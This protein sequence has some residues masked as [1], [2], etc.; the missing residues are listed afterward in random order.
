MKI[1]TKLT[2]LGRRHKENKGFVNPPIYKGSTIIFENFKT[3]IKDRDKND[4][5]EFSKYGIQYNP[6]ADNF[7]KSITQLYNSADTVLTSSGLSALIIPF[8]AFLKNDDNVLISDALYNPTRK[9]CEKILK[10]NNIKIRYFHPTKNINNFEKLINKKTKMIFLES[11][12]TA[13]FD[14]IDFPKITKIAKTYDIITVAD[15]TW[16]SPLFCNPINLGVN[17]VVE[18]ATKYING[19]SDILL[20]LISSDKKTAKKIRMYTKSLGICAGSEET[21]LALR[22]LPTLETRIKE[23]EIN[24]LNMAKELMHND[25]VNKVFHPA[26]KSH[27]NHNIWK[28]DFSGSTGLFSFELKKKYSNKYLEKFVKKL[29]I[30][31]I[32]YSWGGFESLITFPTV[33]ERRFNKNLK[34]TLIRIYC[35]H[36]DN[37]DQINDIL[38]ALKVLK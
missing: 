29:N 32:G 2:K 16:A 36:E 6:T 35:G 19:H 18:A 33:N 21:Y 23:I 28:R 15:N 24:S 20:G 14:I 10:K 25:K 9:F 37:Q 1:K 38:D 22:G 12:G 27:Y 7:E 30:F 4:D 13:T 3:Y 8:L 31:K 34:G 17:I 26:L 11:P 5:N